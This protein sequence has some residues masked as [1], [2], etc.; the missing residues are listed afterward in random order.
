MSIRILQGSRQL[1]LAATFF[2]LFLVSCKEVGPEPLVQGEARVRLVNAAQ[3]SE[4]AEFYADDV[5]VSS[6][7]LTYGEASGYMTVNSGVK[8]AQVT[9]HDR[10]AVSNDVSFIPGFSYTAFTIINRDDKAE[11]ILISDNVGA[12][13]PGKAAVRVVHLANDVFLGLNTGISGG[14]NF[15]TSQTYKS[16]SGYFSVDPGVDL[17]LYSNG[18][19]A[20]SKRVP[21]ADIKEGKIYTIWVDGSASRLNYHLIEYN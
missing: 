5:K 11:L 16:A 21:G 13:E 12:V 8:K 9:E 15:V 2:A 3:N 14:I 20:Y 10:I 19:E 17:L 7:A 18:A 1:L 4:S 6:A